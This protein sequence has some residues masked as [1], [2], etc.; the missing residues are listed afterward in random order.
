MLLLHLISLTVNIT[1]TSDTGA[2]SIETS[3][4]LF[5]WMLGG[6]LCQ[7]LLHYLHWRTFTGASIWSFLFICFLAL[8]FKEFTLYIEEIDFVWFCVPT[9]CQNTNW[10][11]KLC[12][13]SCWVQE[14][15]WM[16]MQLMIDTLTHQYRCLSVT[17]E[18]IWI[19]SNNI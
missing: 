10:R 16:L 7:L 14:M 11:S 13:K 4:W 8:A 12:I 1:T 19:T 3:L 5:C 2:Q 9:N 6:I 17:A 15:S 18:I